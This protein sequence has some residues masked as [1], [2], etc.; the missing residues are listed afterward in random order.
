[1]TQ[2]AKA[3]SISASGMSA[4][5]ER[6]RVVSENVANVD[7]PGYRRKLMTFRNAFDAE[8]GVRKVGL[9]RITLDR[10]EPREIYDP[11]HPMADDTGKVVMS[12]V[13]LMTEIADAREANRSYQA[14][15]TI[16]DQAR[17][18]YSGVLDLL[19]RQ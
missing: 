13:K 12:N 6:M 3:L 8:D 7:T 18:M 19:R 11:T 9:D 4:Q 15:M 5:S 2:F 14:N 1:M 17:R 16:F 10:S